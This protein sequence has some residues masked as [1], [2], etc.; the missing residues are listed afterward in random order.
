MVSKAQQDNYENFDD[1]NAKYQKA[2]E[3][4]HHVVIVV[5]RNVIKL[6]KQN[7]HSDDEDK[8]W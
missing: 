7:E 6:V 5:K 1:Q 4:Q 2:S 8:N 3:H